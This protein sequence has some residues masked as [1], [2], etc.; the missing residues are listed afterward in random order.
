MYRVIITH[1]RP[2]TSV[3]FFNP[4]TS[5]LLT[6]ATKIHIMNNYITPGKLI[7]SEESVS[8]DGLVHTLTATYQS[9]E[10]YQAW[11]TDPIINNDFFG[12]GEKYS[13]DNGIVAAVISME[14]I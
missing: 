4:K 2:N 9:E 14:T 7:H 8:E 3:E 13:E 1:T 12:V 6:D 10:V 11:R 5:T